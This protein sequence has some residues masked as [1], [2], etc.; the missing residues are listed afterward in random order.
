MEVKESYYDLVGK[1]KSIGPIKDIVK[2][3]TMLKNIISYGGDR[4]LLCA[5]FDEINLGIESG[6]IQDEDLQYFRS[7]KI[8]DYIVNLEQTIYETKPRQT[9][10][11]ERLDKV[12][13]V[14]LIKDDQ[15]LA[16]CY[17]HPEIINALCGNGHRDLVWWKD[18]GTYS[19]LPANVK[20]VIVSDVFKKGNMVVTQ[21]LMEMGTY[22]LQTYEQKNS[23]DRTL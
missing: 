16:A 4:H 11:A 1:I 18:C 20:M 3:E 22:R 10:P 5:L 23:K 17:T 14:S 6:T 7:G 8:M 15:T 21:E 12:N 2:N 9:F 19:T 13:Y